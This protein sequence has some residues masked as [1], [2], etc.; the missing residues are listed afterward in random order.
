M[1]LRI[2]L[3]NRPNSRGECMIYFIVNKEWISTNVKVY[4]HYWDAGEVT[5]KKSHPNYY[6]LNSQYG[7]FK[8]RA[9]ICIVNFTIA[10]TNKKRIRNGIAA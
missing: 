10:G 2:Y 3:R 6:Q 4:P 5:I 7:L 1:N 8:A 9:E